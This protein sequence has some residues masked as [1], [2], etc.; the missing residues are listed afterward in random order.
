[1]TILEELIRYARDCIDDR[2]VSVDE[3]Y[4]SCQK[5]KWAC[6][7]FLRDL[8][9]SKAGTS[10][11]PYIWNEGEAQKIVDWFSLLRHSKG[12]LAGQPILLTAWQKFDLCQ[13]YGWR[14]RDTGRKRFKQSF[15]E[16]GRKN[17]R[18]WRLW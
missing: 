6:Q 10:D 15:T 18:I 3:D 7:R 5:H 2:Y 11:F 17:A 1:M 14:H 4:I 13:I 9:R 8:D 12:D 16:V